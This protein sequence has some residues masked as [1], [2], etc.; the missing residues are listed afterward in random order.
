MPEEKI[1]FIPKKSFTQGASVPRRSFGL[2][3]SLGVFLMVISGLAFAGAYFYKD[4]LS[5]QSVELS[6][7][8]NRARDAFDPNLISAL[9]ETSRKIDYAKTLVRGHQ[10][11]T[12]LF[13]LINESTL[14]TVRFNSFD[15]SVA[16]DAGPV[17][18]MKGEAPSYADLAV[19]A[20]QFEKNKNIKSV[21][22]SGLGLGP[23]GD[24]QF[25]VKMI[26]D[27]TFIAYSPEITQ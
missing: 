18:T 10:S 9:V 11:L 3:L 22:F 4:Y 21:H 26:V 19:Q 24:V 1:S 23:K 20:E 6:V 17:L 2:F 15:Y 5:K 14:K 16:K 8:L 25:T 27:S 12:G 13:A 7:S